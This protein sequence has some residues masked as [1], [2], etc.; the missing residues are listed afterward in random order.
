LN[1]TLYLDEYVLHIEQD[2]DEL[3]ALE[4]FNI[5]MYVGFGGGWRIK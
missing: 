2:V 5:A 3:W 4:L 1:D